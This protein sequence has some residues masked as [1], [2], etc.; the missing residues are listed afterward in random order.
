MNAWGLWN[1]VFLPVSPA[2]VKQ[3]CL[4]KA[5]CYWEGDL[6]PQ[7]RE[8]TLTVV[9]T[10]PCAKLCFFSSWGVHSSLRVSTASLGT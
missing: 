9:F 10:L 1:C 8:E 7:T 5:L 4:W 2:T 6:P 3:G